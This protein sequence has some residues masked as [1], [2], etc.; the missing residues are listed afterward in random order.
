TQSEGAPG[1]A[2]NGRLTALTSAVLLALIVVEVVTVPIIRVLMSVHVF[3]GVLMIGPLAVKVAS[4]GWRFVR[5]YTRN[6][7]YR[8]KGPPR[9]FLRVLA[10][11]LLISTLVLV[12]SGIALTTTSPGDPGV[13]RDVHVLSFLVW[14]VLVAIHVLAYI[15]RVPELIAS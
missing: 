13:L 3:I 8:R 1:V 11:L 12:G 10:P 14:S 9:P 4:T 15:R 2:G 7:A 6:P 5:Y